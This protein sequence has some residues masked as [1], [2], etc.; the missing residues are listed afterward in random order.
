MTRHAVV[1]SL[2]LTITGLAHA[3]VAWQTGSAAAMKVAQAEHK[4]L[5]VHF[6][7]VCGKCNDKLDAMLKKGD[8]DP[9]FLHTLDSYV[10]LRMTSRA[11]PD[12]IADELARKHD[13]PLVA[14]YDASGVLLAVIDKR[15]PWDGVIEDMLRFRAVRRQL[16]RAADLRVSGKAPEADMALGT[17]LL[18]VG[19]FMAA[20]Q[21]LTAAAKAFRFARL[22]EPAQLSDVLAASGGMP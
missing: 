20:T 13:G 8:T 12:A 14:I 10:P 21:R 7:D 5:F 11:E 15:A 22:E 3:D 18:N 1:L 9:L 17:A 19:A 6:Q 2:L 4:M 16:V